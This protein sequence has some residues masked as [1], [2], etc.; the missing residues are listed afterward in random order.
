MNRAGQ[1]SPVGRDLGQPSDTLSDV[2]SYGKSQP[3]R[4]PG[5]L[6]TE[7]A[8]LGEWHSLIP[9]S[10]VWGVLGTGAAQGRLGSAQRVRWSL[11]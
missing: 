3:P 2:N 7:A 10:Q 9:Y 6:L 8:Y 11:E 5:G 4:A 1:R